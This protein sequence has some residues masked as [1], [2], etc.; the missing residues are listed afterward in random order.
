MTVTRLAISL[1]KNLARQ[2]KRS[3]AGEPVSTWLADAAQRKLRSEGL[4]TLVAEWEAAHGEITDA[5]MQAVDR[6]IRAARRRRSKPK[7][8]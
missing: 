6:R 2:I 8:R 4:R 3:A 1:E 5:E 7:A